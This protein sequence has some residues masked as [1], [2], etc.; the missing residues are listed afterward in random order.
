LQYSYY[1]LTSLGIKI[2]GAIKPF[3]TTAQVTQIILCTLFASAHLFVSY[4]APISVR[5]TVT[6]AI[7]GLPADISAGVESLSSAA[8]ELLSTAS[9]SSLIAQ[10]TQP[11]ALAWIKKLAFR[12][13]G[14]E[15]LAE[16]VRNSEG[17]VFGPEYSDRTETVETVKEQLEEYRWNTEWQTT[18]CLDTSGQAFAIWLNLLYLAPLTL[19]FMRFLWNNYVQG[20]PAGRRA[21]EKRRELSEGV[22]DAARQT[23]DTIEAAGMKVEQ[24]LGMVGD[25]I[26]QG[27]KE[28]GIDIDN[29]LDKIKKEGQDAKNKLDLDGVLNRIKQEVQNGEE[30]LQEGWKNLNVDDVVNRVKKEA[31][32]GKIRVDEVIDRIK[33][34]VK[35]AA[36]KLAGSD[37]GQAVEEQVTQGKNVVE[38]T[39]DDVKQSANKYGNELGQVVGEQVDRAKQ[40]VK[41]TADNIN[42]SVDNVKHTAD[43]LANKGIGLA[44][45]EQVDRATKGVKQTAEDAK[46][47]A[48][49]YLGKDVGH[50][51]EEQVDRAAKGAR[52][53]ADYVKQSADKHAGKDIGRAAENTAAQAKKTAK[54]TADDVKHSADNGKHSTDKSLGGNKDVGQ[55][56]GEQADRAKKPASHAAPPSSLSRAG[57]GTPSKHK[58]NSKPIGSSSG[59]G[60]GSGSASSGLSG[61]QLRDGLVVGGSERSRVD[62]DTLLVDL[63]TEDGDG[64]E[65]AA[66][67]HGEDVPA[68]MRGPDFLHKPDH[69]PK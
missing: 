69:A 26:K 58:D 60:S 52:E 36:D 61:P 48:Q 14:T 40:G 31:H 5:Y 29:M 37:V 47:S 25:K 54:Q 3:I 43:K 68:R 63:G 57:A 10:A 16:Q 44:A 32:Q 27:G 45:E 41:Q 39:A 35:A 4:C 50:A 65:S 1:A 2:S 46:Q 24:G 17:N 23:S 18:Q 42:Q 22:S 64:A 28:L 21:G 38:Q 62:A 11:Y 66:F 7:S 8:S 20:Q 6:Q 56:I 53:M 34:E 67:E 49:N 19:L 30:Q 15:G 33:K 55:A 12:A 9:L 59:S 51:A 13:A